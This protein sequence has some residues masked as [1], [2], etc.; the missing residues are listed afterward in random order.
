[1]SQK[2]VSWN[3]LSVVCRVLQLLTAVASGVSVTGCRGGAATVVASPPSKTTAAT[4][5]QIEQRTGGD[6]RLMTPEE[7]KIYNAARQTGTAP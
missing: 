5:S 4:I 1:M 6:P 7:R 2:M 3:D